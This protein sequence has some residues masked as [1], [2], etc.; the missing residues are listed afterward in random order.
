MRSPIKSFELNI[1]SVRELHALHQAFEKLLPAVDL[2]EIL[3]AEFVSTVS[4]LDCYLHDIVR[5]KM[6]KLVFDSIALDDLP[7]NFK[8]FQI[9]LKCAK[10]LVDAQTDA[11]KDSIIIQ[12]LKETLY[13]FSFESEQ[14]VEYAMSYIGIRNIWTKLSKNMGIPPSDIKTQ[15]NLIV[16]RRNNIAHQ[17]DISNLM[18]MEK[19]QINRSDVE[20]VINFIEALARNIDAVISAE[21]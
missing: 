12:T 3:R 16:R 10:Q 21:I 11:E 20:G 14:T 7:K 18:T 19:D 6:K 1:K 15:L 17:S 2:S 5:S 8:S 13:K 9:P 4:A